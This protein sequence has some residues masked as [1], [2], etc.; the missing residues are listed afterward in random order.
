MMVSPN[1]GWANAIP[2]ANGDVSFHV[3]GEELCFQGSAYHDH[4]SLLSYFKYSLL[5]ISVELGS[6]AIS[7]RSRT[8]ALGP[9]PSWEI[10]HCMV[11]GRISHRYGIWYRIRCGR[12]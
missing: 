9:W 12:R 3:N 7:K 11:Y 2:D 4:V 5:M 1:I 8:R 10:L 6:S